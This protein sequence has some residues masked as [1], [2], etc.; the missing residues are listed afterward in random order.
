MLKNIIALSAFILLSGCAAVKLATPTQM[1]A[2]RAASKYPGTSVEDLAR[3]KSLYETNCGR[4]HGI[5]DPASESEEEWNKIVPIM[6]KKVNKNGTIIDA[7]GQ[8]DILRYV[9]TMGSAK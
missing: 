5:K 6:V 1:D 3:G 9:V 4:C 8:E 7:K 2:D